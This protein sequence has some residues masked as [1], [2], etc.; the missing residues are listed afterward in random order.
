MKPRL[1]TL[2]IFQSA[3][4][5]ATTTS[6]TV[7]IDPVTGITTSGGDH[8][9]ATFTGLTG[10]DIDI[11]PVTNGIRVVHHLGSNRHFSS[12]DGSLL[13]SDGA[14][15]YVS[16][17]PSFG[18]SPDLSNIAHSNSAPGAVST[19][20]HGIDTSLGTLVRFGG[21]DG[22]PS[23]S[24]AALSTVGRLGLSVPNVLRLIGGGFNIDSNSVACAWFAG[25]FSPLSGLDTINLNTG[26]AT[27]LGGTATSAQAAVPE[28][29]TFALLGSGALA[30]GHPP[31]H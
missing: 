14:L 1:S 21:V 15:A 25:Q 13:S 10:F 5:A 8:T 27:F 24:C 28:P 16:G 29:S 23:P 31:P 17:D 30:L 26:A 18:Q 19:T 2:V 3:Q 6:H 11:D 12:T 9:F 4:P 22:S 7:R 20:L